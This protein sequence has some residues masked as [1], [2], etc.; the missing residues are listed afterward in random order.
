MHVTDEALHG[1]F[2][3]LTTSI[4]GNDNANAI[5]EKLN[6]LDSL[7]NIHEIIAYCTN[8]ETYR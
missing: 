5:I 6:A 2:K 4:I 8:G 1:K 3:K 7:P